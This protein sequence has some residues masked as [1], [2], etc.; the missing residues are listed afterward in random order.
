M[1]K[2]LILLAVIM[3]SWLGS[4]A[5]TE[6]DTASNS[7]YQKIIPQK[8]YA[9]L[10]EICA[11]LEL[12]SDFA[13]ML[14]LSTVT[15]ILILV[16]V[17]VPL[18]ERRMKEAMEAVRAKDAMLNDV[19]ERILKR[20]N[21][22][23]RGKNAQMDRMRQRILL[24]DRTYN[25]IK[26]LTNDSRPSAT[27]IGSAVLTPEETEGIRESVNVCYN[28]FLTRLAEEYPQLRDNDLTMACLMKLGV[29]SRDM[30]HLLGCSENTLKKRKNRMKTE[31]I[32]LNP[33]AMTLDEW[34]L[35]KEYP[36]E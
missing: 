27:L 23:L 4:K 32:G 30:M 19:R 7:E 9:A 28:N 22:E 5:R 35:A 26:Q 10:E 13:W 21:E 18:M 36:E 20:S 1:H 17:T 3:L 2:P 31:R 24:M 33:D 14:V 12:S 34:I 8:E 29:K 6:P 15:A 11:N 16:L 25:K